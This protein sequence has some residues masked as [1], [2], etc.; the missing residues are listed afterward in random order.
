MKTA[1]YTLTQADI[2]A[3]SLQFE[4]EYTNATVLSPNLQGQ[5][6]DRVSATV[7]V[8]LFIAVPPTC[9]VS[10]PTNLV[11]AGSPA[12]FT[13]TASGSGPFT[14]SWSGQNG[15]SSTDKTIT[16][17]NAQAVNAGLYTA[18][19]TDLFGCP[20]TSS[21]TLMLIP[22]FTNTI[23]A[24]SGLILSGSGGTSNGAYTVLSASN[25]SASTSNWIPI[26]SNNFGPDG[27]FAFTNHLNTNEHE[28]FF[29]LRIP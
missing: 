7:E 21:G 13:V 27:Q 1:T 22:R 16:I 4:F 9:T 3:G 14:Y 25:L 5:C 18:T 15:F 20:T 2:D 17:A 10:P 8:N 24:G 23:I 19:V 11:C 26:G 12:S 29:R 6:I 28:R